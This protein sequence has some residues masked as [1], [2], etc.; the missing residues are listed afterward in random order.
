[1]SFLKN[2]LQFK[3]SKLKDDHFAL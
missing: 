1:V 2:D 3:Y